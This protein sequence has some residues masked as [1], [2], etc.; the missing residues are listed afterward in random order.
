MNIINLSD[1]KRRGSKALDKNGPS[2]L[3]INSKADF[4]IT[5]KDQYEALINALEEM[6]DI[7][8]IED[9]K[10]D[11]TVSSEEFWKTLGVDV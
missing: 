2:Y 10:N 9:R 7:R 8:D 6:E 5:P 4:V 1:I 3:V 11:Q